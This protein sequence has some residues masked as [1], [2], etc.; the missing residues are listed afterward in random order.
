MPEKEGRESN[1]CA[2]GLQVARRHRDD[3]ALDPAA[4]AQHEMTGNRLDVPVRQEP[5]TR[6]NRLKGTV[7]KGS[8]VVSQGERQQVMLGLP[9]DITSWDSGGPGL[10]GARGQTAG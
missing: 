6:R 5:L 8:Q 2:N 3:Q 10:W 9:H 4:H 1:R 7:D